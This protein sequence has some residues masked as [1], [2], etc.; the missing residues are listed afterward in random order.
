MGSATGVVADPACINECLGD[1]ELRA[2]LLK[3][4]ADKDKEIFGLV[5]KRWLHLQ[6]TERKKLCARAGPHMLR[7]IAARFTR[8]LELDLSQSASR[9]FYPGVT[10]SDLSVIAASFSCLRVLTLQNCKGQIFSSSSSFMWICVV[11]FNLEASNF[12]ISIQLHWPQSSWLS[13]F[14]IP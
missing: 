1:D 2:V 7:R 13:C 12:D 5:C 14:L 6:S 10:D 11:S 3:L 4:E 9:S 8:L